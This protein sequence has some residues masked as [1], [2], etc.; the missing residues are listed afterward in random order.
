M[1]I[2]ISISFALAACVVA[3]GGGASNVEDARASPATAAAPAP[4]A[5]VSP[6]WCAR[7]LEEIDTTD[8]F[9]D[10]SLVPGTDAEVL[11]AVAKQVGHEGDRL[12]AL[13]PGAGAAAIAL[14]YAGS[15]SHKVSALVNLLVSRRDG[16]LPDEVPAIDRA[17]YVATRHRRRATYVVRG[18]CKKLDGG[19]PSAAFVAA[20]RAGFVE[21]PARIEPCRALARAAA[22]DAPTTTTMLVHLDPT[23]RPWLVAAA[24]LEIEP[25]RFALTDALEC[26]TRRLETTTFPAPGASVTVSIPIE[27]GPAT[28]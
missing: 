14:A 22:T 27:I 11:R 3:C 9:V 28:K 1:S 18:H 19:E 16:N 6:A 4:A 23:G 8:R 20:A 12:D 24:H 5:P 2:S 26:V 13:S 21:V 15:S 25:G 7:A 10:R 17:L